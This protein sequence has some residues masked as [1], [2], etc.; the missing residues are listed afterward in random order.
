M[1]WMKATCLLLLLILTGPK[2]LNNRSKR[3][4]SYLFHNDDKVTDRDNQ[5]VTSIDLRRNCIGND[6]AISLAQAL[7]K[8]ST[9]TSIDLSHNEIGDEGAKAIAEALEKN[10][11]LASM[12]LTGQ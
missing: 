12:D 6:G 3:V 1:A 2:R 11:T 4:G 9:L 8:N 7:E 5:V 10:S